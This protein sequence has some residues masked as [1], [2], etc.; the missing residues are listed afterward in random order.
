MK[1]RTFAKRAINRKD[2]FGVIL[3]KLEEF[4]ED[5]KVLAD[6]GTAHHLH[7][8]GADLSTDT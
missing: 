7:M 1:W 3:A 2:R 5:F 6:L 4:K 8:R